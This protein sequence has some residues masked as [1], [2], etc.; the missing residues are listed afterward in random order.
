MDESLAHPPA[1]A[2]R[3]IARDAERQAKIVF[4]NDIPAFAR[5][6][7]DRRVARDIPA[8]VFEAADQTV[9]RPLQKPMLLEVADVIFEQD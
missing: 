5:R 3:R 7:A 4:A 8:V 9:A 2:S 1:Q 6:H